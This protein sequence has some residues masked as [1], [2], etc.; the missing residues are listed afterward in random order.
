MEIS[1]WIVS[2]GRSLPSTADFIAATEHFMFLELQNTDECSCCPFKGKL[3]EIS[4]FFLACRDYS[5]FSL[6]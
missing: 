1:A 4:E 2:N 6:T 3:K 5:L